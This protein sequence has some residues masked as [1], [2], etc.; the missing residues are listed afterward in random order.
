M[1]PFKKMVKQKQVFYFFNSPF[2][3]LFL[4]ACFEVNA[5]DSLLGNFRRYEMGHLKLDKKYILILKDKSTWSI[6]LAWCV[7]F[8]I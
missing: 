2:Q 7:A 8:N 1:L 6:A 5:Y 3:L 4:F